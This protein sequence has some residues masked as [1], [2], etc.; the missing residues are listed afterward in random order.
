MPNEILHTQLVRT[1]PVFQSNQ[2]LTD[3][4]LNQLRGYLDEQNR[5]TRS[6]L[7]GV[8]ILSGLEVLTG[9]TNNSLS[10]TITEGV[11]ITSEGYLIQMLST[12]LGSLAKEKKIPG[13]ALG[14][15][16]QEI[17][18]RE[19]LEGTN[20]P[21]PLTLEDLNDRL[22]VLLLEAADTDSDNCIN[23]CDD[24][25]TTREFVIRK[26]LIDSS[27]L[28][29]ESED[30]IE[31]ENHDDALIPL[32][33]H[34]FGWSSKE[35]PVSLAEIKTY[36]DF[37]EK[38]RLVCKEAIKDI[39]LA[40]HNI[41]KNFAQLIPPLNYNDEFEN[42]AV[43]NALED[44][45]TGLITTH[46]DASGT[47][48]Y[49]IQY[50][51]DYLKDLALAYNEFIDTAQDIKV[52]LTAES[53]NFPMHLSLGFASG[54]TSPFNAQGRSYFSQP[55]LYQSGTSALEETIRLFD[56]MKKMSTG[57]T[58]TAE[59]RLTKITPGEPTRFK[60]SP[61]S[62]PFYYPYEEIREYWNYERFRKNQSHLI[63]AYA[64]PESQLSH[65][66]DP[67][68]FFRI[69]G[70][71]GS[72]F[73]E[74]M[75]LLKDQ[76]KL[77]NLP[78]DIYGVKVAD[79][80]QDYDLQYDYQLDELESLYRKLRD[81]LSCELEEQ[82]GKAGLES[83]EPLIEKVMGTIPK[84]LATFHYD[85]LFRTMGA[86]ADQY[87][88]T[89]GKNAQ[90]VDEFGFNLLNQEGDV[91]GFHQDAYAD[92][93]T[94]NLKKEALIAYLQDPAKPTSSG[95]IENPAQAG[96]FLYR[97]LNE[98]GEELFR[99]TDSFSGETTEIA[100]SNAIGAY[101]GFESQLQALLVEVDGLIKTGGLDASTTTALTLFRN[102]LTLT[103]SE[104]G[105][106]SAFEKVYQSYQTASTELK[107][108][109]LFHHF[110]QHHTGL[111][112]QAG[113]K[114][115]GTFV[116]AYIEDKSIIEQAL[117]DL[118][119]NAPAN[120]SLEELIRLSGVS[121]ETLAE[122]RRKAERVVGDFHLPYLCYSDAQPVS[123]VIA[124]PRPILLLDSTL[125]C[126]ND[127][128]TYAFTTHPAGGRV[129]GPGVSPGGSGFVFQPNAGT[130]DL[131]KEKEFINFTYKVDGTAD[132]L[133]VAIYQPP[134]LSFTVP[135]KESW[136]QI[137]DDACKLIGI[138]CRFDNTTQS[139]TVQSYEWSVDGAVISTDEIVLANP[140]PKAFEHTFLFA[141]GLTP[142]IKLKGTAQV[143]SNSLSKQ[144]DLS[145]ILITLT[146]PTGRTE[147]CAGNVDQFELTA[148][149]KGGLF[150][151]FNANQ[152]E[153][154]DRVCI[155]ET[156][157]EDG[158]CAHTHYH[159]TAQNLTPGTYKV[160]YAIK[161]LDHTDWPITVNVVPTA[162][163][164][165]NT[166]S[167]VPVFEPETC[168]LIGFN[169]RFRNLSDN[170]T[171][172]TWKIMQGS[173]VKRTETQT[174][175][176][177][178]THTFLFAEGLAYTVTLIASNGQCNSNEVSSIVN[179]GGILPTLQFAGEQ[180]A[181]FLM[182]D[183]NQYPLAVNYPGGQF[184]LA[185]ANGEGE[186][187]DLHN[188]LLSSTGEECS[189]QSY[190]FLPGGLAAGT[191]VLTYTLPNGNS[192]PLPLQIINLPED[193]AQ[194]TVEVGTWKTESGKEIIP[195]QFTPLSPISGVSYVWD[196]GDGSDKVTQSREQT[197]IT[198]AY[199]VEDANTAGFSL[200]VKLTAKRKLFNKRETVQVHLPLEVKSFQWIDL[201]E[202]ATR[203]T[204]N[205][206][207]VRVDIAR[208]GKMT[209]RAIT[210]PAM[211]GS[212]KFTVNSAATFR[213]DSLSPYD[214]TENKAFAPGQAENV[215]T[216]TPFTESGLKG[217]PGTPR[218]ITLNMVDTS[219]ILEA[220]KFVDIKAQEELET[221][222]SG[223]QHEKSR[224]D[225][226]D[227]TIRAIGNLTTGASVHFA[228]TEAGKPEVT[229]LVENV[230]PYEM[231]GD[232]NPWKPEVGTHTINVTPL[233]AKGLPGQGIEVTL[234]VIETTVIEEEPEE[235]TEATPTESPTETPGIP[236][237]RGG[238]ASNLGG[239]SGSGEAA[240]I[241]VMN[242]RLN[243]QKTS[244]D[245]LAERKNIH[246]V[247]AFK[248]ARLYLLETNI[249][250]EDNL[251]KFKEIMAPLKKN[252]KGAKGDKKQDYEGLRQ[253]V[254]HN[255]LDKLVMQDRNSLA[256]P[257]ALFLKETVL[258]LGTPK[259]VK[260]IVTTW[261]A[262]S[263]TETGG[264][265]VVTAYVKALKG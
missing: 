17:P 231:L 71:L 65:L 174:A 228:R 78:F 184:A 114:E 159:F 185:K 222:L 85:T 262:K 41:S 250:Q 37:F 33:I 124:K 96:T 14:L 204:L 19:L 26:Y 122:L 72:P 110:S 16:N 171:G 247:K 98:A 109:H 64:N 162:R 5:L 189:Q 102:C 51:Y 113:V 36:D 175:K 195:V 156:P 233:T 81:D 252:M 217:K 211:V 43:G 223:T 24:Q 196:F 245:A 25:G 134:Q 11:G 212:V 91:I 21:F 261:D 242:Q 230:A 104:N 264:L 265:P 160:R 187:I 192:V 202:V 161:D 23:D 127:P 57:Y 93:A 155:V 253:T 234:Q 164:E 8:G 4:H 181:E 165:N 194:F 22:V 191:Y 167:L 46:I 257:V 227:T 20:N 27:Y 68:P 197:S 149:P 31:L 198:H 235:I 215:I 151:L 236:T 56:R 15:S 249:N 140:Q 137:F 88:L 180:A 259:E 99:S 62:I 120:A 251:R 147:Y 176:G 144:L 152:E 86:E 69:E 54:A 92:A 141:N 117:R 260:Q 246:T 254:T 208:G 48:D 145:Q 169:Q 90:G 131:S 29:S 226:V 150:Q 172:Y 77:F 199:S 142:E 82:Q 118:A 128:N 200:D 9:S 170:A 115:G 107:K 179:L 157:D 129:E 154:K 111:E 89:T 67:Y 80:Y 203:Q 103:I 240:L 40:Y 177:E 139:Q 49:E 108:R 79:G 38:Y 207:T 148:S 178:L 34:R 143:C 224:F 7:I 209:L 105:P 44:I 239:R 173:T 248:L 201:D 121:T 18:V 76:R 52:V 123:Y 125:F 255:F 225:T 138:R 126:A 42:D 95:A 186:P 70:H 263:L 97:L 258:S 53:R 116:L 220:L 153:V 106:S 182:G 60:L 32:K 210:L 244:L 190:R 130:Y 6:Q 2:V 55:P 229:E 256:E 146:E 50:F 84:S 30:D 132:T 61:T 216:A 59:I 119:R 47:R 87:E 183:Q 101:A 10:L 205:G 12:T 241:A 39:G 136:T 218:S 232:N 63:P 219:L 213:S 45:L 13:A 238:L 3:R 28:I 74:V 221:V 66:L 112:H 166:N 193:A 133:S 163:L 75:S 73:A 158:N 135:A 214:L 188:L 94:R 243:L 1:F 168:K 58:S 83:L 100:K 237:T 206:N 35:G